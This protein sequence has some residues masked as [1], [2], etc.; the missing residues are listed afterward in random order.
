VIAGLR[1]KVGP[2]SRINMRVA[3]DGPEIDAPQLI[4][5]STLPVEAGSQGT[6]AIKPVMR[7]V[8]V[9]GL[10]RLAERLADWD[11]LCAAAIEPNL[12]YESWML[13]PALEAFSEG[14][15]LRFVLIY[16]E[17]R[18]RADAEPI[19]CGLFP[20]E[21]RARFKG[22]PV[23]TLSLWRH[24]HCFLCTPPIRKGFE[25]ECVEAFFQWL[26]VAPHGAALMEFDWVNTDGPFYNLLAGYLS[27]MG[28]A[29]FVSDQFTRA[30]CRPASDADSYLMAAI[31]KE[32]RRD[33]R[34]RHKRLSEK[35]VLQFVELERAADVAEWIKTFLS[36]EASGWKGQEGSAFSSS[37]SAQT[38]FIKAM[39]E[40]F[41][42]GRLM[43]LGI[44]LDGRFVA[45]KCNL[46]AGHASFAFKIAYDEEYARF[47]PGVLLELENIRLLHE[48]PDIEW[49]D[50]C[51][52]PN[53]FMLNRL[54]TERRNVIDLVTGTGKRSGNLAIS[55]FP[56]L[57]WISRNLVRK[58]LSVLFA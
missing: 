48:R 50:S 49:M 56:L 20:L 26:R 5:V 33:F 6:A 54:W 25:Q 34:R 8:E 15:D 55:A 1:Q 36:L 53:H 30:L 46:I 51:A 7:A 58:T 2:D 16:A 3:F 21:R 32:H 57:R 18:S 31:S 17:D 10:D 9:E 52:D 24:L 39:T 12:F 23:K 29:T 35:G 42:M 22:L 37:Q 28:K 40:A 13:L 27:E 45:L 14:Q 44:K 43:M 41:D 47:S 11:D 38:F 19:L 4:G